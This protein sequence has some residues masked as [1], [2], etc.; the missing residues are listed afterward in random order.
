[1]FKVFQV[2]YVKYNYVLGRYTLSS[3]ST[4]E[5]SLRNRSSLEW[6]R[7]WAIFAQC[8]ASNKKSSVSTFELGNHKWLIPASSLWLTCVGSLNLWKSS[9]TLTVPYLEFLSK[10][11]LNK[12]AWW[13]ALFCWPIIV[14]LLYRIEKIYMYYCIIKINYWIWSSEHLLEIFKHPLRIEVWEIKVLNSIFG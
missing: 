11:Q 4:S 2:C 14:P 7:P 10:T 13:A 1:M 8:V 3:V 5:V 12:N 9:V 6:F